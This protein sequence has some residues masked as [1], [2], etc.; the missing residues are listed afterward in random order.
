[1]RDRGGAR[2][3]LV[4]LTLARLREFVREP[5]ALFWVFVFPLLMACALGVAFRA[6]GDEA[7]VAG[8][9]DGPGRARLESALDDSS[10][11][12]VVVVP[13]EQLRLVLQRA[14]VQIVVEGTDPP[15]YHYDPTGA[16]RG[17]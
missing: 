4:E 3:P 8:V 9:L 14:E 17:R 15:I 7:V 10:R 2:H 5:E 16:K 6:R 11:I 12:R 1:M 13:P